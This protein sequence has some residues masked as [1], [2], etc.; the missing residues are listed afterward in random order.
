MAAPIALDAHE[1]PALTSLIEQA[2]DGAQNFNSSEE[3]SDVET[4]SELAS[5]EWQIR[6]QDKLL[7]AGSPWEG[8]WRFVRADFDANMV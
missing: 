1:W 3:V 4:V 8:R 6:A 7:K 5:S 2:T